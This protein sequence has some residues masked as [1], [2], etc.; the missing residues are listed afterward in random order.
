MPIIL[1]EN[2]KLNNHYNVPDL[3]VYLVQRRLSDFK[4]KKT[5]LHRNDD[6]ELV[7]LQSGRMKAVIEDESFE[8]EAGD[9]LFINKGRLH[10]LTTDQD[11]CSFICMLINP[12]VFRHEIAIGEEIVRQLL[13]P[14]APSCLYLQASDKYCREIV[15]MMDHLIDYQEVTFMSSY[16]EFIGII[17]LIMSRLYILNKPE[18]GSI[19]SESPATRET[20]DKILSY[21]QQHYMEKLT[22][23]QIASAGNV[24][25]TR[26]CQLFKAYVGVTPIEYLNHHRLTISRSM[27][28]D[29]QNSVAEISAACGFSHQSYFAQQF[30]RKYGYTPS[31]YRSR[32]K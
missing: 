15:W 5:G 14:L 12:R 28:C 26:C 1:P 16:M 13:S 2:V 9:F 3:P 21:I 24:S 25:R 22:L 20:L 11:D 32:M 10:Q 27:L 4:G 29:S 8:M 30:V 6:I 31:E 7:R 19:K 23:E 18:S 17:H